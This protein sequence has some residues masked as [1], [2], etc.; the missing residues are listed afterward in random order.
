MSREEDLKEISEMCQ[1]NL[2]SLLFQLMITYRKNSLT[3]MTDA[4]IKEFLD[5][6]KNGDIAPSHF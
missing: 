1:T 2:G 4:E 6:I 5:G 3:D